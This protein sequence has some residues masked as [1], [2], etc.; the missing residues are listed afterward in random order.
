MVNSKKVQ[1]AALPVPKKKKNYVIVQGQPMVDET[2]SM[3]V[4]KKKQPPQPMV[5]EVM[6]SSQGKGKPKLPV[7]RSARAGLQFPV[8]RW[9][10]LCCRHMESLSCHCL[11]GL[12]T[13][14]FDR[15]D[16]QN[17]F[18]GAIVDARRVVD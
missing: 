8:G 1:G 17:L 12:I 3:P 5:K 14:I 16:L 10:S 13:V 11:R 2:T 9:V 18:D 7:S 6:V 4:I 15:P